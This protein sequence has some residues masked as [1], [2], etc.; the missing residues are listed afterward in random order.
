LDD[1][2]EPELE[3]AA[4]EGLPEPVN[5]C[6]AAAA[7]QGVLIEPV[8]FARAAPTATAAAAELGV[9]TAQIVNS[10]IF[11]LKVSKTDRK[12]ILVCAPGDRRVDRVKLAA[13]LNVSKNK[14]KSASA[15]SVLALTGFEVGGVAPCGFPAPLHAVFVEEHVF[16]QSEVWCGAGVKPATFRCTPAELLAISGG[17]R[18]ELA[19]EEEAA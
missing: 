1:A 16:A 10:L 7:A 13:Q 12:G 14:I 19:E 17:S 6:K 4:S 8:V 18:A 15:A 2:L 5:K 3:M 9:T 11:E